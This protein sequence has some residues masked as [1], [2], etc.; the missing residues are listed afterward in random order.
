MDNF[1]VTSGSKICNVHFNECDIV[2]TLNGIWKLTNVAKPCI[3]PG[4]NTDLPCSKK[5]KTSN[6]LRGRKTDNNDSQDL[7]EANDTKFE[8]N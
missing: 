8:G 6:S 1:K 4:R 2:K 5:R 3:W 7:T